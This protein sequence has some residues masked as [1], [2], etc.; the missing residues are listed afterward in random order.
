MRG[1]HNLKEGTMK[2]TITKFLSITLA[3]PQ[4]VFG[5][6][7]FQ[8]HFQN[9]GHY[10]T[11]KSSETRF[12]LYGHVPPDV[13]QSTKKQAMNQDKILTL[14]IVLA[15]NNENELDLRLSSIT[16]PSSP[17]YQHY[18][19]QAEFINH[20]SPTAEQVELT[21]KY[22]EHKGML[23]ESTAPN[24]LII[25]AS[26]SVA[27]IEKAFHTKIYYYSDKAGK[28]FYAPQYE[29]Q[30]DKKLPILSVLGLENKIKPKPL[31][32]RL[33]NL[34]PSV[35]SGAIQGMTPQ[36]IKTAYSI[37][38]NLT[39][40]GQTLALYQLDGYATSDITSYEDAFNI[41]HVTLQNVLVDGATGIPSSG[42]YPAEVTL[43]IEMMIALA[44]GVSKILVYEGVMTSAGMVDTFNKIATDNLAK[45]ISTSYGIN[46]S[47]NAASIFRSENAI[48]KQM[49]AQ[50]QTLFAATGDYGAYSDHV[51]LGIMDPA[52][53]P[54][55][56]GVGGTKLLTNPDGSYLSETTWRNGTGPG[57]I[58]GT[59][60]ISVFWTIPSWQQGVISTASK[61]STTMRNLPDVSLNSDPQ[62]GYAVF[63]NGSW[64][65]V[66]GTSA[67]APLWAA[68]TA[69][70]NQNRANNALE[71]LGFPNPTL[72]AL[73]QSAKYQQTFHDIKDFSTNLYYP[74]VPAYDLATGWGTLIGDAL[75][76]YLSDVTPPVTCIQ[77]NPTVNIT[78]ATQQSTPGVVLTYTVN[79]I[80]ND[81]AIC[82][83]STF[84]LTSNL[85]TGFTGTLAQKSLNLS[86]GTSKTASITVASAA[87]SAAG[88]Y[89]FS[90]DAVN[91]STTTY[92][93]TGSAVYA[94]NGTQ[95]Q[96]NLSVDPKSATYSYNS[97]QTA[98]F[99]FNLL[100][101]QKPVPNNPINLK[102]QTPSFSWS[103]TLTTGFN[104]SVL[105][106]IQLNS[107]M[108]K[109]NYQVTATTQ[110]QGNTATAQS[111]FVIN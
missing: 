98:N 28:T 101:G 12:A 17:D 7:V 87:S 93:G 19:T 54:F 80:N 105:Y 88:N 72:Y 103:S 65:V 62:T 67:A 31:Y 110:Y 22:L 70:V 77:A 10:L 50:G 60:G 90:V 15:L 24:R 85:P 2:K 58:G 55:V 20:Y 46:E 35:G 59:G 81:N 108:T 5:S 84:N 52:S 9:Y 49:V 47:S 3:V 39:G 41:P 34:Q 6:E 111:N 99:K 71:P 96:L 92:K 40:A 1:I 89:T 43:D 83:A 100:N 11:E 76:S 30:T 32:K 13:N 78:P 45:S 38:A 36:S 33:K 51:T 66:G 37:P 44:P 107:A 25:R 95:G 27:T 42:P 56:V 86:P 73:G 106:S 26:G 4:L 97:G 21:K 48:F 53:Q 14:S 69:L 75:I 91:S 82:S 68:F 102:I 23:I 57:G 8:P 94:I 16:N 63:Y 29:L 61:G 64:S 109:G 74:A 79:V 104:G 18:M